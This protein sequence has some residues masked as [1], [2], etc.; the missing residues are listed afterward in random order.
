M[1]GAVSNRV[2]KLLNYIH[3]NLNKTLMV[4]E[5]ASVTHCS[6][7]QIQR[8]FTNATG[9]SIAQYVRRLKLAKAAELLVDTNIRQLDIVM[10][11]GFDSEISF[12]RS[13][14]REYQ[15]TPGQYRKRGLKTG[16]QLPID[17]D[18]LAPL[19]IEQKE[20]FSL[21]GMSSAMH[22]VLSEEMD[23][24]EQVPRLWDGFFAQLNIDGRDEGGTNK[25][26]SVLGVID[27]QQESGLLN[28]WAGV[29]DSV[30]LFEKLTEAGF[31]VVDVPAQ[32]YLVVTHRRS[33]CDSEADTLINKVQ[34]LLSGWFPASNYRPN[35][36]YDL[37]TYPEEGVVEYWIPI[38]QRSV[39]HT[40]DLHQS[41]PNS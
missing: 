37:E 27:T 30:P 39:S 33:E 34:W 20:G 2:P 35:T 24:T 10:S 29:P 31:E 14:K 16:M 19:R 1:A 6:R 3:A 15:C 7:W 9:L 8:D 32:N 17:L 11:C 21:V 13:F 36:S 28:Y 12:H 18:C 4:D 25:K 23:A 38:S 22:G 5:L 41:A 40:Q 26:A